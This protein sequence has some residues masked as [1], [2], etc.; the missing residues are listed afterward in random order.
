MTDVWNPDNDAYDPYTDDQGVP[1]VDISYQGGTWEGEPPA[2]PGA[3]V[4]EQAAF[5]AALR[6]AIHDELTAAEQRRQP[7]PTVPG[8]AEAVRTT[9]GRA[10][11]LAGVPQ[12]II[13]KRPARTLITVDVVWSATTSPVSFAPDPSVTLEGRNTWTAYPGA[14][15]APP[16]S[17]WGATPPL[18][19]ASGTELWAIS[20][21]AAVV[22]WVEQASL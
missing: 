11:L 1:G 18:V 3:D 12:L 17:M 7:I 15:V 21:A 13:P 6:K 4:S 8:R 2:P 9:M 10:A 16:G 14:Q 5:R 22:Q 19:L 20:N